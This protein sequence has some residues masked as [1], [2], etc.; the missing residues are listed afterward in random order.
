MSFARKNK[1]L[2]KNA[3]SKAPLKRTRR[4]VLVRYASK[5]SKEQRC[6][7]KFFNSLDDTIECHSFSQTWLP[8]VHD[9]LHADWHD[10][11]HSPQPPAVT[12]FWAEAAMTVL[13]CFDIHHASCCFFNLGII[14]FFSGFTKVQISLNTFSPSKKT[15]F[16]ANRECLDGCSP[17][18]SL[19][20]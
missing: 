5:R 10:A 12:V 8:T 19:S 13:I 17:E 6:W 4:R 9:V 16:A 3:H 11:A 1:R 18:K 7:A 14:A 15:R 20:C 2:F